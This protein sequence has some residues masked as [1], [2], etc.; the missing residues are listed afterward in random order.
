MLENP[1]VNCKSCSRSLLLVQM[2]G[3]SQLLLPASLET[4]AVLYTGMFQA[5]RCLIEV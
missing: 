4:E 3:V 5:C 2:K 1:L